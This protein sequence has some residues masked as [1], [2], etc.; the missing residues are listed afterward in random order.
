MNHF[1]S[2][3]NQKMQGKRNFSA[4]YQTILKSEVLLFALE[5]EFWVFH[6]AYHPLLKL[7]SNIAAIMDWDF[8]P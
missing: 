5:V 6:S 3:L 2:Q 1:H 7:P 4:K 8:F